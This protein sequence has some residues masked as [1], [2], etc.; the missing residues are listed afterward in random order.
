MVGTCKK[1][2]IGKVGICK[3][4]GKKFTIGRPCDGR[5]FI[6]CPSC[7]RIVNSKYRNFLT[8][9]EKDLRLKYYRLFLYPSYHP[10]PDYALDRKSVV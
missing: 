2:D 10:N 6:Y 3:L 7:S 9:K 8:K 4:C 1:E 5:T